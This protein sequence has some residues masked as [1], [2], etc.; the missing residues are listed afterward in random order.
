MPT[1]TGDLPLDDLIHGQK[2]RLRNA[3]QS[4]A[5]KLLEPV[6]LANTEA[7]FD[8]AVAMFFLC[9]IATSDDDKH[10]FLPQWLSCLKFMVK[11][12]N[13]NVEPDGFDEESKEERRR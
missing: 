6:I 4:S 1:S 11:Q 10:G 2:V 8:D 7:E 3:L 13:L 5:L 9:S 12:L